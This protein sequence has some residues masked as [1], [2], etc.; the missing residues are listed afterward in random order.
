MYTPTQNLV[1]DTYKKFADDIIKNHTTTRL[2]SQYLSVD[3]HPDANVISFIR[4]KLSFLCIRAS[5]L[6]LRGSRTVRR[7]QVES[8]CDFGLY[9][10]KLNIEG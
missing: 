4:C 1:P 5:L 9:N 2:W 8:G 3:P 6:C 10:S 7:N